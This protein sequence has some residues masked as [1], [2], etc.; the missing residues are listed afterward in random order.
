MLDVLNI[1]TNE[2]SNK[3]VDSSNNGSKNNSGNVKSE[4]F[5]Q[6][7]NKVFSNVI[8]DIMSKQLNK[9]SKNAPF[10]SQME[11]NNS[12]NSSFI[13]QLRNSNSPITPNTISPVPIAAAGGHHHPPTS[14]SS[15]SSF[16]VPPGG[17]YHSSHT[18]S[19]SL[20]QLNSRDL[21]KINEMKERE[22]RKRAEKLAATK[23]SEQ[24]ELMS[25]FESCL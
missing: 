5:T 13:N 11:V 3:I 19:S 23:I 14:S 6:G 8:K 1:P 20:Q 24:L 17:D 16:T 21:D 7:E 10:K 9:R 12:S 4:P 18:S 2:N 15:S 22:R 25:D